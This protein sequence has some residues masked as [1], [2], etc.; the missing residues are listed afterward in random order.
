MIYA[1]EELFVDAVKV[2]VGRYFLVFAAVLLPAIGTGCG[3]RARSVAGITSSASS[4]QTGHNAGIPAPT[5]N[6]G[7]SN[8]GSNNEP[9]NDASEGQSPKPD[10]AT[11]K[12]SPETT[13]S[14][15]VYLTWK[16]S[17]SPVMGYNIYRSSSPWGPFSRINPSIEPA[18]VY[19]D[20]TVS[21]GQKYFYVVTAV[22]AEAE[23]V[24]SNTAQVTVPTS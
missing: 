20:H 6:A 21:A 16:A 14:H 8:E 7:V 18:T 3:G 15:Y 4:R 2:A 23:S 5:P 22:S 12:T 24:N 10:V 17:T 19:A 9:G 1:Q 13:T 11:S